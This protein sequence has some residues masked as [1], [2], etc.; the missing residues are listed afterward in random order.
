MAGN[1]PKPQ[2]PP[3]RDVIEVVF[4]NFKVYDDLWTETRTRKWISLSDRSLRTMVE[5][6]IDAVRDN[7]APKNIIIQCFQKFIGG[8]NIELM[9]NYMDKIVE[10]VNA[11]KYNKVIFTTC[12]F[13]V[14][15]N[16]MEATIMLSRYRIF[17]I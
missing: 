9:K 1:V 15:N 3:S 8:C 5:L 2:D 11:Q 13:T 6:I 16:V 4:S 7:H 10:E 12:Y 17:V 14:S